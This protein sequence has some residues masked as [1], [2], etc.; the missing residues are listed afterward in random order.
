MARSVAPTQ[1][2]PKLAPQ[3]LR[4]N[5]SEANENVGGSRLVLNKT[6][7]IAPGPNTRT[8]LP[9]AIINV[10][11]DGC[12]KELVLA[13]LLSAMP[14]FGDT[15]IADVMIP[16]ARHGLRLERVTQKYNHRGGFPYHLLKEHDCS[17]IINLKLTNTKEETVSHFVAWDGSIIYDHPYMS[18]VN[19][20]TD[21]NTA[22]GSK[23]VFKK[24]YSKEGFCNYQVTNVY[25]LVSDMA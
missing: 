7:P 22:E 8:C 10:L 23:N 4:V 20:T 13:D 15:R 6:A 17:L 12:D 25:S 1:K 11:P 16:L 24:M 14:K 2:N 3:N 18:K 19:N 9:D 5:D 21:R